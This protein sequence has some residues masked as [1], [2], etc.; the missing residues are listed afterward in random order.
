MSR[1]RILSLCGSVLA[2]SVVLAGCLG[3]PPDRRGH[4]TGSSVTTAVVAD[5]SLET[6]TIS[7]G[8]IPILESAPLVIG[9]E[10]GFFAKH[11]LEVT[12]SKQASWSTA[13]DNV[14]LGS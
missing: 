7:L 5:P 12:L 4:G 8:F 9:V 13:R 14:V 2:M 6:S 1:R 3:N 11:G 10:K